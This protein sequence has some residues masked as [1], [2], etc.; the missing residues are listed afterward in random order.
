MRKAEK[1][2]I[3]NQQSGR[4]KGKNDPRDEFLNYLTRPKTKQAGMIDESI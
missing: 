4:Y 2:R 3:F 1:L